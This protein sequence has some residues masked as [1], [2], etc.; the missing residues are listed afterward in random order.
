MSH[1]NNSPRKD[2]SSHIFQRDKIKEELYIKEFNWT[3]KQKKFIEI[4]NDKNTNII[5]C[6]SPPG[7]GKTL[8][9][10]FCALSRLKD[11]RI[12]SIFYIRNPIESASRGIGYTPGT[13]EEKMEWVIQ[14]LHDQ[15]NQLLTPSEIKFLIKD[16]RIEGIPIG[17]LKGRTFHASAVILDEAEDLNLQE[18]LLSMCRIGKYSILFII[19]DEKQANIKN[20][21][22]TKVFNAFDNEESRKNGIY[23][24]EFTNQDCMRNGIIKY[25][26]EIFETI[27]VNGN[28]N[29]GNG[30]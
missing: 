24:L 25:I 26:S 27:P 3:G 18:M 4:G 16:K 19:G 9:S 10:I 14:P 11:K 12:G 13:I 29:S 20:S 6:K 21:A 2:T 8:C 17:Y 1:K 23:T 7:T 15:L 28:N 5:I 22:F 30:H